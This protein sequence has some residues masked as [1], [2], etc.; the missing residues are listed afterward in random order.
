[1]FLV[2]IFNVWV[3]FLGLDPLFSMVFEGYG[4]NLNTMYYLAAVFRGEIYFLAELIVAMEGY[5]SIPVL[6]DPICLG[7]TTACELLFNREEP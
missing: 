3:L 5:V 7:V 1:M 2:C 6:K 4:M